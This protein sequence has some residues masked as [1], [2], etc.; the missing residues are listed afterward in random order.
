MSDGSRTESSQPQDS[1]TDGAELAPE[2]QAARLAHANK[3]NRR[4][5]A[6]LLCLEAL[7]VLLI[8]RAIAFTTGLGSVRLG[9]LIGLAVLL[10]ISAGLLRRPWGIAFGSVLQVLFLATG[11]LIT[12]MFALGVVFIVIWLRALLFRH[13]FLGAPGGLRMLAG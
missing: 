11:F 7:V 8:P 5:L 3:N 4:V 2:E 1:R 6:A 9:I 10:V 12:T 13:E